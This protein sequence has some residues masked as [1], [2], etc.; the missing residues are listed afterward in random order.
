M[1]R[2]TRGELNILKVALVMAGLVLC[3]NGAA[4][5]YFSAMQECSEEPTIRE[6]IACVNAVVAEENAKNRRG[7][8]TK[9]ISGNSGGG[10]E[11]TG[12]APL[13]IWEYS[14]RAK[15]QIEGPSYA[16]RPTMVFRCARGNLSSYIKVAMALEP[17]RVSHSAVYTVAI[18]QVDAE[19]AFRVELRVSE[20]GRRLY[21]P[22]SSDISNAISGKR[23][24]TVQVTPY[25]AEPAQT[26]FD[27]K[28]FAQGI[29]P[30]KKACR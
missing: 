29:V 25:N 16:H 5:G 15:T 22:S 10:G 8:D 4:G 30:L 19:R 6:R 9:H 23:R 2:V 20:D 24:L 26:T 7:S 3:P 11:L 21:L 14:M 28:H 1:L 17:D 27:L 18:F 12:Q 13:K